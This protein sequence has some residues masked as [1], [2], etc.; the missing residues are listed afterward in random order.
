MTGVYS[1]E[2]LEEAFRIEAARARSARVELA[3]LCVDI[4]NFALVN[5]VY[6]AMGGDLVALAALPGSHRIE[7]MLSQYNDEGVWTG[8][9]SDA[10]VAKLDL[11]KMRYLPGPAGS[12]TIHNCRTLHYSARNDSDLGR[13]LLL[14]AMT[15]ADAFPYTVNPIKPKHDQYILRGK[16]ARFAHHDP[17][18]CL[19]PPDWSKGYTSIFALQQEE[20]AEIAR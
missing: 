4:D 10:D 1:R 13:P 14:N 2:F 17:R 5:E 9:L 3:V 8:C 12:L 7:P 18:P 19:M 11:S 6:G 15:S 16:R 20:A